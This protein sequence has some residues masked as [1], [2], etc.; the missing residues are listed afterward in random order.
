MEKTLYQRF[1]EWVVLQVA[2][3][4]WK[5]KKELSDRQ[6]EIIR[7]MLE[8]D[9][10]IIA[11]RRSN[12]LA[13]WFINLG[14][15]LFSGKWGYYT[16]VLMNLEDEVQS[17]EDFRLIEATGEGTTYSSFERVFRGVEAAALIKPVSMTLDEWT[18]CLDAVKVH[19]GK[20]YD[21]LFDVKSDK[22]INCVELVRLA[23]MALPDY[24]TRFAHFE[25]TLAKRP[26][27]TPQ[28]FLECKDFHV[29]IEI[30]A[31]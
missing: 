24:Q 16:H 6:K 19:L 14:H 12:Y 15:F 2:K 20:P 8:Q 29:Y 31:R 13:S 21:N 22:E 3:V 10:F 1:H 4:K 25:E 30:K 27:L 9:Y 11:T 7:E 28:T 5:N 23:L 17:P 26:T 18:T